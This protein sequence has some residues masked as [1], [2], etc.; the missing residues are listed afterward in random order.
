M[1]T[2]WIVLSTIV[3][4]VMISGV[5]AIVFIYSGVYDI[6]ASRPHLEITQKILSAVK[7]RS[8]E[9]H[10]RN[11]LAPELND[12]E[13]IKRGFVLYRE[14]CVTCH[15]A[16]GESRTRI[17]VG[18]NPNPPPLEK[19]AARW[20]S[21]EIAWITSYGL[22]MAG[23]PAFGIGEGPRDLWA[24]TAFVVRMNSLS[25]AEYRMMRSATEGE[26]IEG[27][28]QWLPENPGWD[29]LAEDGDKEQGRRLLDQ[30]GCIACHHIPGV[31]GIRSMAGQPLRNWKERH[32]ISGALVNTPFNLVKWIMNPQAVQPETAMPNLNISEED[33]WSIAKYLYTLE[34]D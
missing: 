21:S 5:G 29:K 24:L 33:A 23:M 27:K 8:I 9:V 3:A 20:T 1:K 13:L 19:A 7:R 25:P 15:G 34:G 26:K 2:A 10:S 16:P 28:V 14:N 4:L 30:H 22:K 11:L 17:G 18:V 32:Y 6:A 12:P 31:P